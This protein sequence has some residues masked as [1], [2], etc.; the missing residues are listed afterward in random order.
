MKKVLVTFESYGELLQTKD[1]LEKELKRLKEMRE[2]FKE[3][4]VLYDELIKT[5]GNVIKKIEGAIKELFF[6]D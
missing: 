4:V 6:G 3:D 5:T 1:G 2:I